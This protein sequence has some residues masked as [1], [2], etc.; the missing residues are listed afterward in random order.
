MAIILVHYVSTHTTESYMGV[1]GGRSVNLDKNLP[2]KTF[3]LLS[4]SECSA[5]GLVH[6]YNER[7]RLFF[8]PKSTTCMH[9]LTTSVF[10]GVYGELPFKGAVAHGDYFF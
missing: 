1:D 9:I 10:P 4:P 8:L 5:A 2:S 3:A 6:K 7:L